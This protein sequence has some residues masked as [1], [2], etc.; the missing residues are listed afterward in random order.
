[1]QLARLIPPVARTGVLLISWNFVMA[2]EPR[3]IEGQ[4]VA[5]GKLERPRSISAKK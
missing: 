3:E 2:Y 5:S 4:F 1:M